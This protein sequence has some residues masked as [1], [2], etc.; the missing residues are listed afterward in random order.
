M[1]NISFLLFFILTSAFAF[2]VTP[3]RDNNSLS[4]LFRLLRK[5]DREKSQC[6]ERAHFWAYQMYREKS[7]HSQKAFVYF[8][9][10]YTQ[11]ING[12]WWFHVAPLVTMNGEQ[13]SLD[14]EFLDRPVTLEAWKNG[15]I[16]H[17]IYFLT[18]KKK[19]INQELR[20]IETELRDS[21]LY[22]NYRRQLL[23]RKE[24]LNDELK[25]YLIKDA[26]IIPTTPR[27]F[28]YNDRRDMINIEC[29]IITNYSEFERN[30]DRYYCFIQIV[31]MYYYEPG[32]L[33]EQE[34]NNTSELKAWDNDLV[35][36]AFA[37]AFRGR[38]PYY[39]Q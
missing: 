26:N 13:Y 28:P 7:V 3:V 34:K 30:Q 23:S 39:L 5:N 18:D 14:P 36:T 37:N 21:S 24:Y 20:E 25:R 12:Q 19:N 11:L 15:C 32:E 22:P 17:A 8:T 6:F 35:Y 1:Y 31:N 16:D 29:P 9:R 10:K 4:E 33:E 38:F 2:E 27:N